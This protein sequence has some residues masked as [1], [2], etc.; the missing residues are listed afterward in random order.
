MAD[1][2]CS[3]F[4]GQGVLTAGLIL[5]SIAV[6]EGLEVS[7]IPSYGSEMRGGLATCNVRMSKERIGSPFINNM[8]ILIAMNANSVNLFQ[9]KVKPGGILAVNSSLVPGGAAYRTDIT[10]VPIEANAL[11]A[12]AENPRGLNIVM[13]AGA[14][15]AAKLFSQEVF[16][17]GVDAYFG[18]KGRVNPKNATCVTLGWQAA[19]AAG[20]N[21]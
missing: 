2:K 12:Q 13:L 15:A 17:K 8:D 14:I 16:L 6:G 18:S 21:A 19:L 11:A 9:E 10:V 4:G 1:I 5:S 7:W 20:G 3:G